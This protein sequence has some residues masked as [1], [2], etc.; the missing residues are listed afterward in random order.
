MPDI[1]RLLPDSV[2]NQ[3]AAGEVIQRPA[4][5]VKELLENAIDSGASSIKLII[6]EAGKTL[7]QVID[8]GC[9]MSETDARMSFERHATS[10]ISNADDLFS[11]RTMGFRGEALASIASIAQLELKTKRVEDEI[12]TEINIEG[13]VLTNQTACQTSNG[14]SISIKNLFF[15]VPARRNFLKSNNVEYSHI[16]EE[17]NR[18]ALAYHNISFSFYNNDSQIFQ[19]ESSGFK[20]R[21]VALFGNLYNQR[22]LPVEQETDIIK[23]NGFVGNPEFAKKS[24]GEQYFFVNGRFIKH[25]YLN[26]AVANA[27]E[28]TLPAGAF[29]SYFIFMEV[30]PKNIDIN[31][32]PT[33]TEVKLLDEK[34]I[35]SILRASVRQSIGKFNIAPTIDFTEETSIKFSSVPKGYIPKQPEIAVNK[36][37]NPFETKSIPKNDNKFLQQATNKDHWEKLFPQDEDI[38]KVNL[39]KQFE[40]KEENQ[41]ISLWNEKAEESNSKGFFQLHG[42]YI[43]SQ[44]KSGMMI[45]DQQAAQERILFEKYYEMGGNNH[46]YTQQLLFPQQLEF[47][48]K[49][50][51]ILK[52]LLYDLNKIGFDISDFGNNTFVINGTPS[53][54]ND[55]NL[56]SF[57]EEV[58]DDYKEF[59]QFTKADKKN[60]VAK[61]MAKNLA[62]KI[63]RVLKIEEMN[64]LIDELFA[65][66]IPYTTIEGK[67][68]LSVIT[69]DEIENKLKMKNHE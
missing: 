6:K 11:I 19:L 2:A 62:V 58:I 47:G 51:E 66:K 65:C 49:D 23:I 42:K 44:I 45:I 37:F 13:S 17:F 57:I 38:S 22:L 14:T 30:D 20:Q 4:S 8:N 34:I 36:N 7:I 24:R 63:Q 25:A 27:F 59:D 67:S 41:P 54:A 55:I 9:G 64:H 52:E 29:P 61:L 31:I 32:H 1:I 26:H 15:N 33:K 21:I 46:S 53:D 69:L 56:Q 10:K 39:S 48:A 3:I 35:Y 43:I 50:S 28:E 60:A 16:L 68:T 5:A 18:V 40:Q 12:G